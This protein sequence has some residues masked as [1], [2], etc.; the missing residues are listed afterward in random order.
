[1]S[2]RDPSEA[3]RLYGVYSGIVA[4]N[5]DPEKRG[6]LRLIIP[7]LA[8][9]RIHPAWA[10]PVGMQIGPGEGRMIVPPNDA[11]V[12]VMF[13]DGDPDAPVWMGAPLPQQHGLGDSRSYGHE[14]VFYQ[15]K[16]GARIT[17]LEDNGLTEVRIVGHFDMNT[18]GR[19]FTLDTKP[20][21]TVR[22]NRPA[23]DHRAAR[24]GDG[25]ASGSLRVEGESLGGV[26]TLRFIYS[27]PDGLPQPPA[28]VTIPGGALA[29]PVSFS[30]RSLIDEGSASVL[31]GD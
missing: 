12:L 18:S 20:N 1:M 2:D 8:P 23:D 17:E 27:G 29:A 9:G 19:N 5:G 24:K 28:V 3:P 31:I 26:L 10:L 21:G 4:N 13:L 14:R 7:H 16:R 30:L 11:P 25:A 22:I 15:N 6:R